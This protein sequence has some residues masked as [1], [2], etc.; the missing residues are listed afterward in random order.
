M[1]QNLKILSQVLSLFSYAFP[2]WFNDSRFFD[3]FFFFVC[4]VFNQDYKICLPK[5]LHFFFPPSGYERKG[6]QNLLVCCFPQH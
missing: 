4:C 3:F 1:C 6:L 5:N 2:V